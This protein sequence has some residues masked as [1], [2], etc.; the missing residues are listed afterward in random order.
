MGQLVRFQLY[1]DKAPQQPI[2]EHKVCEI[3]VILYKQP[4]LSGYKGESFAQFKKKIGYMGDQ[5]AL[6]VFLI[7]GRLPLQAE[8]LQNH[9]VLDNLQR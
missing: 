2:V 9:G 4:F 6:Q 8:K 5:G 7:I 1:D 3:F